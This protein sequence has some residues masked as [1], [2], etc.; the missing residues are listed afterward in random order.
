MIGRPQRR[1]VRTGAIE[2][3]AAGDNLDRACETCHVEYWYPGDKALLEK[4]DRGIQQRYEQSQRAGKQ[5]R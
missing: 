3:D 2:A 4:V 1:I 5:K